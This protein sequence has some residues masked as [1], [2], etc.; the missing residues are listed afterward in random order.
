MTLGLAGKGLLLKAIIKLQI[1]NVVPVTMNAFKLLVKIDVLFDICINPF[2]TL[3]I[4][5]KVKVK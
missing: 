1:T 3:M 5:I 2:K 4:T